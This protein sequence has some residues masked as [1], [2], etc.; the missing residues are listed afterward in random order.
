M[1]APK[2]VKSLLFFS[3]K[4]YDI[5]FFTA[6]NNSLPTESQF[7]FTFLDERLDEITS[8]MTIGFDAVCIFV[9][10]TCDAKVLDIL[11]HNNI[12]VIAL[13]CAGFNNVDLKHA[14]ELG[15]KVVRVPA[16][17]PY[18]VAEHAIGLLLAL[19]RKT[20]MAYNRVREDNFD[21]NGLCGFNIYKKT[22]GIIGTGKIGCCF[23]SICKGF[24][25]KLLGYDPYPSKFFTDEC[26]GTY[27]TLEE[28]WKSADVISL[29][30]P[31]M[32]E[33]KYLINSNTLDKMKDGVVIINTS[34]GALVNTKDVI[35]KLKSKKIGAL[36]I[37]V[38]EQ[39]EKF[40]FKDLSHEINTDDVL[41]RLMT[42]KNVIITGHQ[43]FFTKEA[44]L[45]ISEVT[46]NNLLE[47]NKTSECK[48]EVK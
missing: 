22:V 17:S 11:K 37:D 1:E 34:R 31:L 39:E 29:H 46:L 9:N 20:H 4:A 24:G 47:I 41:S 26:G 2:T 5:S 7:S 28:I 48:N 42:F 19:N 23:A 8:K 6:Y 16:Y 27:V 15:I 44:L 40:F 32:P 10:D 45:A 12:K 33:T 36:G 43:A 35:Q 18:A 13:R 14:K 21:I 38:Y 25:M 3:S 30:V